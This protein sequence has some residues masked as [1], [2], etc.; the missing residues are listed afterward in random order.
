M[1]G[2]ASLAVRT[3]LCPHLFCHPSSHHS[4]SRLLKVLAPN[5]LHEEAGWLFN[6]RPPH[7]DRASDIIGLVV[8][9]DWSVAYLIQLSSFLFT[10]RTCVY[11]SPSLQTPP[12]HTLGLHQL[13]TYWGLS[14]H[15]QH[16][17]TFI[18][19]NPDHPL[20]TSLHTHTH[21]TTKQFSIKPN[22]GVR[23]TT[24]ERMVL[25]LSPSCD[26]YSPLSVCKQ[27][28]S[29]ANYPSSQVNTDI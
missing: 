12:P 3:S 26:L 14:P 18:W 27:L 10:L 23:W 19:F 28:Y 5:Y 20:H 29:S 16:R 4:P 22:F 9:R 8:H 1:S 15:M 2:S 6:T 17:L 21:K 25:P 24:S 11:P 7:E 13:T